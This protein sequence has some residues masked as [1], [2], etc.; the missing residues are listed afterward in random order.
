MRKK[1][2]MANW[3]KFYF[4]CHTELKIKKLNKTANVV[5]EEILLASKMKA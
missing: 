1:A 5:I 3:R 2:Y 4:L